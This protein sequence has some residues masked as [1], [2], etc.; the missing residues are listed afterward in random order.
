[1]VTSVQAGL[2][3]PR[4]G[5]KVRRLISAPETGPQ[6]PL[7]LLGLDRGLIMQLGQEPLLSSFSRLLG[8]RKARNK[9]LNLLW[10]IFIT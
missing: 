8:K 4:E 3:K 1:M 2:Q 9:Q 6:S 5:S 7:D 10:R